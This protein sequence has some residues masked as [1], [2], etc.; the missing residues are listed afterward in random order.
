MLSTPRTTQ[1]P[2]FETIAHGLAAAVKSRPD[3]TITIVD[4]EG[5]I[6]RRTYV[7]TW[8]RACKIAA[9]LRARSIGGGDRVLFSLGTGHDFVTGFAAAAMVGAV[10]VPVA[11]PRTALEDSSDRAEFFSR[12]AER[13]S[14]RAA[15]FPSD[16]NRAERPPP[17]GELEHILD[18][19]MLLNFGKDERITVH[20]VAYIQTT[21]GTTGTR[22]GV[23]LTHE[24][25]TNAV[26]SI[27]HA[28][29]LTVDDVAVS[30]LPLYNVLGLVG[31]LASSYVNHHDTVFIAPERFATHPQ[32]WLQMLS[33]YNGTITAAPSHAFHF[34]V[35]RAPESALVDLDLSS[36]RASIVG[37]DH[38][39]KVHLRA[40]QRRFEP[41]GLRPDTFTSV[42][43]L[44]ES[45][46]CVS[47]AP[48]GEVKFDEIDRNALTNEKQIV[49]LDA[50]APL[51]TRLS[52]ASV[53]R[54]VAGTEIMIVDKGGVEVEDGTLGEIA[55]NSDTLMHRYFRQPHKRSPS[56]TT[57]M[58]GSWL[59]TG[60]SGYIRA[61]ELFV[62]GRVVDP[63]RSSD[64]EM[65]FPEEIEHVVNGIDGV[66]TG[67]TVAFPDE[68]Q[69]LIV[70]IETQPGADSHTL[71]SS[72]ESHLKTAFALTADEILVLTPRSIP[73]SPNG[74]VRRHLVKA[75]YAQNMLE[76]ESRSDEFDGLRRMVQRTR[77]EIQKWIMKT[78]KR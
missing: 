55:V 8:E 6:D 70:A 43:G 5:R 22:R 3:G 25:V 64:G 66:R 45:T 44:S 32:V 16:D 51:D 74:K 57:R 10:P 23:E 61:G 31:M 40:F 77:H 37:G 15:L 63:F 13:L 18:V 30:W 58:V 65:I 56:A 7:Q 72:V 71:K 1:N 27:S 20:D 4:S 24:A 52:V 36:V 14:V 49:A 75:F 42:Y 21:S 33:A 12:I 46:L 62:I 76:R 78:I 35:R 38:I 67:C 17:F 60:D 19:S 54:P 59:M 26:A 69:R 50:T 68:H 34:C 73:R 11:P 41:I 53:G 48:P 47:L 39:R 9:G 29:Q 2:P 28:M